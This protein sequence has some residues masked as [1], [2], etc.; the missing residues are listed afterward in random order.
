MKQNLVYV[1]SINHP[2]QRTWKFSFLT[3]HL[4]VTLT[5]CQFK[6]IKVLSNSSTLP[7]SA[8]KLCKAILVTHFVPSWRNMK[9][10]WLTYSGQLVIGVLVQIISNFYKVCTTT[11][12][13]YFLY[14]SAVLTRSC[15]CLL[16]EHT[17]YCIF[18]WAVCVTDIFE[19]VKT[20]MSH[21]EL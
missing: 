17:C 10:W 16:W 19:I 15:D 6:W 20:N 5:C 14:V 11:I 21:K 3:R 9:S 18:L 2:T 4:S 8:D 13:K 7:T 1:I 12:L